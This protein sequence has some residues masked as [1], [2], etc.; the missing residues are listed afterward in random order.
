MLWSKQYYWFD[1]ER[2]VK[3]HRHPVR[4]DRWQHM[5]NSDVISMPDKW[6]YPWY[7]AWDLAFHVLPLSLVDE[8]FATLSDG[9]PARG[10]ATLQLTLAPGR[11]TLEAFYFSPADGSI[12]AMDDHEITVS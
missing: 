1:L 12:Q 9:A 7:A 3:E 2:W 4:N 11:Y 8:D 5:V 6:E 10:Q